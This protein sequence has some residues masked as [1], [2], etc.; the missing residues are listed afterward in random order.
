MRVDE[1]ISALSQDSDQFPEQALVAARDNWTQLIPE[2]NATFERVLTGDEISGEDAHFLFWSTLLIGD[3]KEKDCFESLMLFLD[4]DDEFGSTL[5]RVLGDSVCEE[6]PNIVAIIADG[7]AEPLNKILL[8][9]KAG[10]YVKVSMLR[11]LKHMLFNEELTTNYFATHAPLWIELMIV[12]QQS[13]AL[14]SL[15]EMLIDFKLSSFQPMYLD[16]LEK[17]YIDYG[18]LNEEEINNWSLKTSC[19]CRLDHFGSFDVMSVKNWASF[20]GDDKW[21]EMFNPFAAFIEEPYIAD[22]APGR[23]DPCF[24]GSG[25]KYKKCCLN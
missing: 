15:G 2:I 3:R 6:L 25:K 12:N 18:M 20:L 16:F 5:D 9:S 4:Q 13:F 22:K 19:D 11:V 23:N 21:N 10:E 1:I 7:R 14:S 8:S 17:D 24:C